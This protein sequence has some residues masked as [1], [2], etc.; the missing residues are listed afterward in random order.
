M[1][2]LGLKPGG[3]QQPWGVVFGER[4]RLGRRGAAVLMATRVFSEE[5]AMGK[6]AVLDGRRGE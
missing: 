6:A 2:Q 1:G 5:V 3:R 4:M